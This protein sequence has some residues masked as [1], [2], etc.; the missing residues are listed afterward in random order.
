MH[1]RHHGVGKRLV[2]PLGEARHAQVG[3]SE[4][5]AGVP[6]SAEGLQVYQREATSQAAAAVRDT[7][8]GLV[9]QVVDVQLVGR[10]QAGRMADACPCLSQRIHA[11]REESFFSLGQ[12]PQVRAGRPKR[13]RVPLI[14]H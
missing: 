6:V 10:N 4:Q 13:R 9:A 8:D 2:Q 5:H 11:H 12:L 7:G 3:V 1:R 14:C